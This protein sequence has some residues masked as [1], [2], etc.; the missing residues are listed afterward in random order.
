MGID[1]LPESRAAVLATSWENSASVDLT[2]SLDDTSHLIKS[3]SI[4]TRRRE[5]SSL[6]QWKRVLKQTTVRGGE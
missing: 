2:T 3:A 6:E 1:T 4:S 5:Y